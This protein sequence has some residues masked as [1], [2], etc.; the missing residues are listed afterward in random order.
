MDKVFLRRKSVL[1]PTYL[2]EAPDKNPMFFEKRVY[3]GSSGRVYPLPYYNRISER[4]VQ[5]RWDAIFLENEFI[6]VMLLPEI[7]GRIHRAKDKIN[8]YDFIYYQPVI[9]PALVGLAGPWASGGIEFNW[10]QHHRPSTF[11]PVDVEQENGA[12]GSITVWLSE[13]DPMTRMKGM[14]GVCLQPGSAALELKVRLY[15]RTSD[16]QTFLWWANAA[17][18]VHDDYQSF[19]PSDVRTVADHAKRAVST[20]PLCSG[21]YYGIDYGSRR[22]R[23]A[24]TDREF[25][26]APN[27]LSWYANIP[28]PTSYMCVGSEGDFFG[29][30]D[31]R[32]RSGIVHVANHH[33]APGKKQWTWGNH[34][35]GF[36]W[37]RNL[38]DVG[39]DGKFAPYIEL[40]AG[41]YTD[42]QPDFS[43]IQPGETKSWSQW[44]Y[45]I[46]DIGPVQAASKDA[47]L[48]FTIAKDRLQF[49]LTV[50]RLHHR[51]RIDIFTGGRKIATLRKT[52]SPVAALRQSLKLPGKARRSISSIVVTTASGSEILRYRTEKP[53][54]NKV[55]KPAVEPALPRDVPSIDELYLIGVHLEQYRHATRLPEPYWREGLRRDPGDSRCHLA[56]GRWHLR[57]GEFARAEIHLRASI[58]RLTD[59][60]SNPSDGEAF[61]Q[62]GMCL[63]YLDRDDDAYNNLYKAIWSQAWQAAG[64]HALAE[65]DCRRGAWDTALDHLD[66]ALCSNAENLRARNLKVMVLRRLG[67]NASAAELLDANIDLDPL[68]WWA[69]ALRGEALTCNTQVRLDLS[70][71]FV[72]AGFYTEAARILESASPESLS[73]T[74]PLVYYY[75]AWIYDLE[76][77][78][79]AALASVRAAE[80][81]ATDYCF[82]ARLEE[83]GILQ[84]AIDALP[85]GARAR[86]Y[87]GN[88][89]Y[90]RRRHRDAVVQWELSVR[91]D[92]TN[93]IAW[94]NLGIGY[95]NVMGL[96][97]KARAAYESAF[98]ANPRDARIV[99]EKDQLWKRLG[100]LPTRRLQELEKY[101][102]MMG[103]RDD[104][105]V[106]ICALYNQLGRSIKA[107]AILTNRKFQPWEG[108]EGLVL[109]QYVRTHLLLG[110]AALAAGEKLAALREFEMAATIPKNLGESDHPL[111]NQSVRFFWM[112]EACAALEDYATAARHWRAAANFHGDFQNM[113]A[114]GFSELTY[115]TALGWKR[116][117]KGRKA[118]S[119]L[120]Q[121][122]AYGQNL[123]AANA[124]VDYFATSL[125]AM[126]LF[127]E[128]PQLRQVQTALFLQAQ[129]YA[130]LG[131]TAIARRLLRKMLKADPNHSLAADFMTEIA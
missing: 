63:R 48:A 96:P 118:R 14:H 49:C 111:A 29:G 1:L 119:I 97:D 124:A 7:G 60:N 53:G 103:A 116:L 3:Q 6:Q 20:F 26:R 89:L 99:Y 104:L 115:Y 68:D 101:P 123:A 80:K 34:E 88:L 5:H 81:A 128:N 112:G 110:R 70:L 94:R 13:H 44:W 130:G 69:R 16:V 66:R 102:E 127:D 72:R 33:I 40:M 45:P 58:E 37:D 62:L 50:T 109:G 38:T 18:R 84:R 54:S 83:I 23:A 93:A 65:I 79:R 129:A 74:A 73:G 76:G 92:A 122:L 17:V 56:L 21:R 77:D 57:R 85:T 39:P 47:A 11:M 52:L 27:D 98:N 121:L 75:R 125:P 46:R 90:D 42:N 78:K 108:G 43:F 41:V 9:K 10:P 24:E 32:A 91:R 2:P 117:G 8:G 4:S 28:V 95:Y 82:P 35:F 126:L 87:L 100:V 107:A 51:A 55:L 30:Y 86:Y 106:E 19:F 120:R 12:D 71:D 15:N 25:P 36:S 22:L 113:N 105:S 61:Y 59:R 67:R 64:Y 114:Q 31:F 131:E